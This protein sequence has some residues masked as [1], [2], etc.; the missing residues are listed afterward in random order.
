MYSTTTKISIYKE[1]QV[2]NGFSDY[3]VF[4]DESGD[5]GLETIDRDYL[6]FVLA[7][8]IFKKS[9]YTNGLVHALQ[10]FKFKHFG[11]DQ[12]VL[13]E[14]DIRRDRG[15]F[16][17]LKTKEKK[18]AFL[19]E[20]S[21]IVDNA[22]FVLITTVINKQPYKLR[23][24]DPVNPYHVALGYGLERVF[25]YLRANG[26]CTGK[27]HLI[28]ERRGKK[29]D[30]ELELEFRRV[31]DGGNYEGVQLPFEVI[32]AGKKSNSAGLQLADLIAR[33][34]GIKI[35]RPN[36]QNSAYEIIQTKF[37]RNNDGKFQ[38]WGLKI[39]P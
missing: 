36:Q 35:L 22:S 5:H 9:E 11:H 8:C 6:I 10:E 26:G 24:H 18:A 1:D 27:T 29:E 31:C 37:Y 38:G 21:N 33:P 14:A 2:A 39:F 20:L 30:A 28:V 12:V 34:V 32:F 3:L 25:Y 7:F 17:F 23:Y 16:S 4:V 13:H 19:D 15:D